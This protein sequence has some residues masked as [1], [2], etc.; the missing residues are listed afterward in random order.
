MKAAETHRAELIDM[1][2]LR[3][4]DESGGGLVRN[5]NAGKFYYS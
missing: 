4:V 3:T 1:I 2:D 5:R